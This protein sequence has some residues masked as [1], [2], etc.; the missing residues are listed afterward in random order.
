ML[1][2]AADAVAGG[3]AAQLAGH[4]GWGHPLLFTIISGCGYAACAACLIVAVAIVNRTA[5][6]D[7]GPFTP[8]VPPSR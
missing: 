2:F 1:W 7:R 8:Q 4:L 6:R 5:R 3:G